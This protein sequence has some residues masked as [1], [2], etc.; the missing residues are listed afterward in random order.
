MTHVH[1]DALEQVIASANL[2][3]TD[4][5][6]VALCRML[7]DL[8]DNA[9]PKGPGTRLIASYLTALRSLAP[10]ANEGPIRRSSKLANMRSDLR[11]VPPAEGA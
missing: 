5:A 10:A 3:P 1:R 8:M 9:G 7:A 2:K 4:A 11:A 6:I